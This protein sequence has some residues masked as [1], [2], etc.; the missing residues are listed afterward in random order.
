MCSYKKMLDKLLSNKINYLGTAANML[1]I[2]VG[3]AIDVI[4]WK[5]N[6]IKK[7][8]FSVHVQCPW[9]IIHNST[10]KVILSAY[11]IDASKDLADNLNNDE[12]KNTFQKKCKEWLDSGD[13]II[14][15]YNINSLGDLKLILDNDEIIEIYVDT[16][17]NFEC[18]RAFKTNSNEK[19]LVMSGTGLEYE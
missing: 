19:H 14:T 15:D 12:I 10:N 11:D 4:D 16:C 1:C 7:S 18:W 13:K 8:E 9:R 3:N 5:G 6:L 17:G 2:G